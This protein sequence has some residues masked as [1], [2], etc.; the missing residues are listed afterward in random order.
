MPKIIQLS[1]H[2]ANL[3]AAGEVVERPASV[4][5]ELLENA[6]DAG[7]TKVTVEIRDGGMTFL[8]VTDNGCGMTAED[9][10]TAF[11]RHATSKLRCAEDLNAI[12]TMGFR[13]EAL[14]A[15]S[16]VSRIDLLTKT[17]DSLTGISLHLEAGAVTE[18]NEADYADDP[19]YFEEAWIAAGYLHIRFLQKLPEAKLHR[20]SL[21]HRA[22]EPVV[23]S[24]GYIHLEYRYNTYGD[25]LQ[26]TAPALV[27]YRLQSLPLEEAKGIKVRV[28]DARKGVHEVVFDPS[29]EQQRDAKELEEI[30]ATEVQ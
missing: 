15:I 24:D 14:A 5:K 30:S 25:T 17:P 23:A 6:V 11:L 28:N 1:P 2:I 10:R 20:V 21:V 26:M 27:C 8:R 3:I 22:G 9:A 12:G 19:T 18:E 16:S 4:A 29:D 13:G 7:A